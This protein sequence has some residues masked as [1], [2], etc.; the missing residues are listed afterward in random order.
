M[1][2]KITLLACLV[3]FAFI[4]PAQLSGQQLV[5]DI[6]Q[7]PIG[8]DPRGLKTAPESL[9]FLANS[10]EFGTE[11]FQSDGTVAGTHLLFDLEP[12]ATDGHYAYYSVI[13]NAVYALTYDVNYVR[14]I[15]KID[16]ATQTPVLLQTVA[17]NTAYYSSFEEVFTAV[18]DKVFF[19]IRNS[20]SS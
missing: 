13:G 3:C 20:S 19:T 17:T 4:L 8:S 18:G 2:P 7:T 1:I 6:N 15:W 16:L 12:G 5:A 9:V 10:L 11:L 14:S